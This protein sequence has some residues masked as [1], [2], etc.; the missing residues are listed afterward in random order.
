MTSFVLNDTVQGNRNLGDNE[1]GLIGQNGFLADFATF[2]PAVEM[3]LN[4][5]LTVNG[6]I[7]TDQNAVRMI[8]GGTV[9][10]ASTG[11]VLAG[12]NAI[13]AESGGAQRLTNAGLIQTFEASVVFDSGLFDG[14]ATITNSGEI[15]SI[16]SSAI[17]SVKMISTFITNH[18]LIEGAIG[19]IETLDEQAVRIT[20]TGTIM[21]GQFAISIGGG[22]SAVI[23]NRGFIDGNVLLGNGGD[24]FIGRD[25]QQSIVYGRSGDDRIVGGQGDEFF[26]GGIGNDTLNGN[27][28]EDSLDGGAGADTLIGGGGDDVLVGGSGSDVFLFRRGHG[29][30]RILDFSD[31]RDKIDLS[32]FRF[33]NATAVTNVAFDRPGGLLIDLTSKGGGTIFINGLTDANFGAADI[34]LA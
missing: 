19:G 33:A 10:I 16:A 4:S 20:N 21:G 26:Y 15:A 13:A 3:F 18:G 17:Y 1:S 11:S 25:G 32:A 14:S 6:G 24:E 8:Q 30:D 28:G 27:G 22:Q 34:I 12:G 31:T 29:D 2:Q 5:F 7:S 9:F 23:S